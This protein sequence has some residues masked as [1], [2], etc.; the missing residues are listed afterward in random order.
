MWC[1][2]ETVTNLLLN[3]VLPWSSRVHCC[4]CGAAVADVLL[5]LLLCCAAVVL[6]CVRVRGEI[7]GFV[8]KQTTA[9]AFAK[10]VSLIKNEG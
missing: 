3:C 5:F 6:L 7:V 10:D 9:H 2:M 4:C 1:R 8:G